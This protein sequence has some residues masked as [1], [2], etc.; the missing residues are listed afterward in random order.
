MEGVNAPLGHQNTL[1]MRRQHDHGHGKRQGVRPGIPTT[2]QTTSVA[3]TDTAAQSSPP[4]T[5]GKSRPC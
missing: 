5:L 2:V 1:R 4:T 3:V